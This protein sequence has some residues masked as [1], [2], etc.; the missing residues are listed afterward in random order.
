MSSTN[1]KLFTAEYFLVYLPPV[2][3][4]TLT[5]FENYED[6]FVP[7]S[8]TDD[9]TH[10]STGRHTWFTSTA[11][12]DYDSDPEYWS[13]N[14]D[15]SL[16]DH[17]DTTSGRA[18]ENLQSSKQKFGRQEKLRMIAMRRHIDFLSEKL[19]DKEDSVAEI[20]YELEK[21]RT[22]IEMLEYERNHVFDQI[23]GCEAEGNM[24]NVYRL[25]SKHEKLCLELEAEE[26]LEKKITVGLDKAELELAEIELEQGKYLLI[27][28][29]LKNQEEKVEMD[30]TEQ[31][32]KRVKKE[33]LQIQLAEKRRK[34]SEMDHI[35]A[36]KEKDR[37]CHQAMTAAKRSREVANKYLKDTLQRVKQAEE[38]EEEKARSHMDKRM[39]T[40]LKLR[41]DIAANRENIKAIQARDNFLKQK[42]LVQESKD[43]EEILSAGGNAKALM[44][45]KNRLEE[46]EQTQQQYEAEQ[47]QKQVQLVAEIL[48]EEQQMKKRQTMYPQ[49][50]PDLKREPSR[51]A[52]TKPS[53]KSLAKSQ[54][55]RGSSV[56]TVAKENIEAGSLASDGSEASEQSFDE[57]ELAKRK[58]KMT[59]HRGYS[60]SDEFE[61]SEDESLAKPEFDGLWN[62]E[63]RAYKVPKDGEQS[64]TLN[65]PGKMEK[66]MMQQALNK[67]KAGIVKKQI[68]AG[69]EFKGCPFY[70]KP[71]VIHFKD[72]DVLKSYKKKVILTNVSYSVN[73]LK[74]LSLSEHLKDFIEIMFDPPGQMSAGMSCEMLVTFKPMINEDLI[75][76]V[77]FL[78]QTGPFS[79]PVKCT[80]KKCNLS[81]DKTC[82]DFGC[83]VI[84]E[85]L[86]R[87]FT[88]T[89]KGAKGTTFQFLKISGLRQTLTSAGTSL[90]GFT[91]T[92]RSPPGDRGNILDEQLKHQTSAPGSVSVSRAGDAQAKTPDKN[93]KDVSVQE[94]AGLIVSNEMSAK[95][96]KSLVFTEQNGKRLEHVEETEVTFAESDLLEFK[97]IDGMG[98]GEIVEGVLGPFASIKLEIVFSPT[99]P[100]KVDTDF[101]IR[102]NDEDSSPISVKSVATAIDVPVWVERENVDLKICMFDRLYQDAIVVNNR[103][104]TAL[105]LKFEVCKELQNHLELLPKTGYI[106]AQSQFSAQ[107]KFLPRRSIFEEAGEYFDQETGVLE[108]PMTIRVADQTSPVHFTVHAVVTN[109]DFELKPNDIDFG[110]CTIFE[111]VIAKVKLTNKSILS[112]KFGFVNLPDYVDVQPNDGFGTLLPLETIEL[113]V[114]FKAKKAKDYSFELTCKS[115][116]NRDFKIKCKAVGVHPPLELSHSVIHFAA[117][118]LGDSSTATLSVINSH[119]SANEF[120]HPVPRI[121]KGS[122]APVG[123]TSFEFII[124]ENVPLEISPVVGTINPGSKQQVCVRF[125]P[126]VTDAEIRNEAVRM[127]TKS[128][129]A[130]AQKELEE[131]KLLAQKN[132]SETNEDE[133]QKLKGKKPVKKVGVKSPNNKGRGG[134]AGSGVLIS[135]PKAVTPPSPDD[136][137]SSSD[138]YSSARGSLY[139]QFINSFSS[140]SIPC[141]V[142]TGTPVD[143]GSLPYSVH[144]TLYMEVHCP[145]IKPPV[146]V[147]SNSGRTVVEFDDVS[148]GQR[149]IKSVT[150][151]NI[152]NVVQDLKSSVLD[153]CGPFLLLNSMRGL[154]PDATHTLLIAF[155]PMQAKV[156]YEVLSIKC[157]TSTLGVS[158]N[159][160]GVQP[161]VSTS[162]K[163]GVLDMGY[164][165]V[166]EDTTETFKIE[167]TSSLSVDYCIRLDSLSLNRHVNEQVL[168]SFIRKSNN[169]VGTANL[170]GRNV[171][172]C[173]PSEGTLKPG[174]EQEIA[175]N[176]SP[177][178]TSNYFSDCA[179][180]ELYGKHEAHSICLKGQAY[181]HTM[182]VTGGD[183]I[184]TAVESLAVVPQLE[185][186]EDN[187]KN[188]VVPTIPMLLMFHAICK[189]DTTLPARRDIQ[190]GC[191]RSNAV[192]QKKNGEFFFDQLNL[193]TPKGFQVDIQKGMVEAGQSKAISIT[194]TPPKGHDPNITIDGTMYLN[195]K[196]DVAEK[197]EI[198]LRALV[199]S[200]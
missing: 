68:A 185:E 27:E 80:T 32:I 148:I 89:N 170:T 43:H 184:D 9:Q 13:N 65:Y 63:H 44:L 22:K 99:I 195:L 141:F 179:R 152:S 108:A 115:G 143:P 153:T 72:F 41:T 137:Q 5:S 162:L 199:V 66:E 196:G 128:L 129:E 173:V 73:F 182:Y 94:P 200:E 25:Q 30:R 194:W 35:A 144:N 79:V 40:L 157:A 188:P 164:V 132:A 178:H 45:R 37:K 100:G 180:I 8:L 163:D 168:P 14:E 71:D 120:T 55:S 167:N 186:E 96:N 91:V 19:M 138:D 59:G 98:V 149:I 174:T 31:A 82:I 193:V 67:H 160:Q 28:D 60:D 181:P 190:V 3:M 48:R 83:Q 117:T 49:L 11:E 33:K 69:K 155:S 165:I 175:V 139:R 116:I 2:A 158:L 103:A 172:D 146:V 38:A 81:V 54:S 29:D 106:Q 84:G 105:R 87:T 62:Q 15:V 58:K 50:W 56:F 119:T 130:Q 88:L 147:I 111:S 24:A 34:N 74:L 127:I 113:D 161:L 166:G 140:Y 101:E 53:K 102:F 64:Y 154:A 126:K 124:P 145:T 36:L 42:V 110:F 90:G 47:K 77:S 57:E 142:A 17:A 46:F 20:R 4:E 131:A 156:Y 92:E 187:S 12:Q 171:F 122:I 151:Q 78:A 191:I 177:D 51:I 95:S 104:K 198:I 169:V 10:R 6:E 123:P 125:K 1:R 97:D 150:I 61:E 118:A 7:S 112:H 189:E 85:K 21:C 75:G 18:S 135:V 16:V 52:T 107:I 133:D 121:G 192:S 26:N 176:F 93:E 23:E 183:D 86:R 159:G 114:I 109:S 197:Y 39:N 70:S 76:K 134:R 136:I